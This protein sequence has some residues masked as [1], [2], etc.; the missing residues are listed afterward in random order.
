M[1]PADLNEQQRRALELVDVSVALAAGAGCGKTKVLSERFL[2]TVE[3]SKK[4]LRSIVAL[5][6]TQKAA[7]E[8]RHR[9]RDRVRDRVACADVPATRLRWRSV[10]R[11]LEAAPIGTFHE[12]CAE[13][14]RRHAAEAEV[15]PEFDVLDAPI[16]ETIRAEALARSIRR[17]LAESNDDLVALAVELGLPQVRRALDVF[18]LQSSGETLSLWSDSEPQTLVTIWNDVWDSR[19][20]VVL[21][22]RLV[23]ASNRAFACLAAHEPSHPTMRQRRAELLDRLPELEQRRLADDVLEEIRSQAQVKGVTHK[24][25]PSVEIYEL[26]R[27][28]LKAFRDVMDDY[29][30]SA[31][32]SDEASLQAAE[33]GLRLSR[34]ALQVRAEYDAS[35]RRRGGLDF[36]DLIKRTLALLS[37]NESATSLSDADEVTRVLVDEFQDT[38]ETQ[39]DV[40]SRLVGP[41]KT[42]GALFLVGDPKQSIYRF[43]GAAPGLSGVSLRIR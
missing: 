1:A 25:W 24:H 37:R 32:G 8:L 43:R 5:T 13:Y 6:F 15:D 18:V 4:S 10:L 41:K 22:D 38:D 34:L 11:A 3:L 40:I 30:K 23:Q 39:G 19:V 31:P 20:R 35:K 9:I 21:Y 16:A 26:V 17:W 36:D 27:D 42:T 29:L 14:L 28:T 2:R 7:R 12:F 33:H